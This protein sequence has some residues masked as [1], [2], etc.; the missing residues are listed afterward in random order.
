MIF[1]RPSHRHGVRRYVTL[2]ESLFV[3]SALSDQDNNALRASSLMAVPPSPPEVHPLEGL[4]RVNLPEANLTQWASY[5]QDVA[6]GMRKPPQA[7]A[8]CPKQDITGILHKLENLMRIGFCHL[9]YALG[10]NCRYP[11]ATPQ[12]TL[13]HRDSALWSAPLT[14]YAAIASSMVTTASTSMRGVSATTRPP[15]GFPAL[16]MPQLM[17]TTLAPQSYSLLAHAGAGRG[18]GV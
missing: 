10:S 5:V 6:S 13:S 2:F 11:K 14:S 15:P 12:A 16:G 7:S 4:P 1:H 18:W 8:R 9:F 3:D 17:D